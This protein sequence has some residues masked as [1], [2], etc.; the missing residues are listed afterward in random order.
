MTATM[1]VTPIMVDEPLAVDGTVFAAEGG[2]IQAFGLVARR[3]SGE[4][5]LL[6]I[7]GE[8]TLDCAE[9]WAGRLLAAHADDERGLVGKAFRAAWGRS[10]TDEEVE[11]G[12]RFLHRQAEL[13][14]VANG[15]I[16]EEA[17]ADFCH[18]LMNANEFLYID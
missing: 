8:F 18:A 7:N 13:L 12:R 16:K 15:R 1:T 9:R 17:V 11:L 10:A 3:E 5:A 4:Q 14:P 6:L 2:A